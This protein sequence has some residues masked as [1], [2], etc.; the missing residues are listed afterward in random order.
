MTL[1]ER[2]KLVRKNNKLNQ[3]D[4]ASL[5]GISQT[6]VSKIEKDVENPSET[7]LLL[8]SFLFAINIDW[9]KNEQG[10]KK[11]DDSMLLSYNRLQNQRRYFDSDCDFELKESFFYFEKVLSFAHQKYGHDLGKMKNYIEN[12]GDILK[13]MTFL[14]FDYKNHK[15]DNNG[16]IPKDDNVVNLVN[17]SVTNFL[18]EHLNVEK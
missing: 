1:G 12:F 6:H 2:I 10:E 17:Q 18:T 5:L 13:Y 16:I 9:L 4:F 3:A 15:N 7:L 14:L 8:I 11:I